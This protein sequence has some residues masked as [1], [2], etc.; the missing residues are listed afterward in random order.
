MHLALK[1]KK[2][3]TERKKNGI[4]DMWKTV[5]ASFSFGESC[6]ISVKSVRSS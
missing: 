5:D 6:K 2:K 4:E 3:K 1:L